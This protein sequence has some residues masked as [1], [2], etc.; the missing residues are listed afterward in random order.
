MMQRLTHSRRDLGSLFR[1]LSIAALAVFL[2]TLT[3][4]PDSANAVDKIA[5]RRKQIDQ[6]RARAMAQK[7]VSSAIDLQINQLEDNGLT[8]LPIYKEIRSM[9]GNIGEL[10]EA[11]M[12]D[13]VTMLLDAQQLD[14]AAERDSK[15]IS[16]RGTIRDIVIRLAVERHNLLRRLR[17]AEIAE[18]VKRLIRLEA[19][20]MTVTKGLPEVSQTRREQLAVR[21]IEDQ[22][23]I[24][25]LFLHLVETLAD[26][27]S[28]DGAIGQGATKG[29]G[30]LKKE[31]VG[32]HLDRAGTELAAAR[33]AASAIEQA[34]VVVGLK[35]LLDEVL[36]TQG[37][38]SSDSE[39]IFQRIEELAQK[40]S[41][42]RAKVQNADL[43]KPDNASDLTA[44]QEEFKAELEEL[45]EA[46]ADNPQAAEHVQEAIEAATQATEQIFSEQT[47]QA[48]SAQRLVEGHLAA[49]LDK[50]QQDIQEQLGDKTATELAATV[51]DLEATKAELEQV[52]AQQQTASVTAEQDPAKAAQ[53]EKAVAA[54]I[55]AIQA[56]VAKRDLP[57][58]LE[59]TIAAADEAV[60]NA[61]EAA[62]KAA[63]AKAP[64]DSEEQS[65][66]EEAFQNAAD[67]VE[68]ALAS[69]TESLAEAQRMEAAVKI[70]ELARA[71][72]AL[73]RAAAAERKI[74]ETANEIA[75]GEAVA[76]EAA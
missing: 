44:E 14:S 17:N 36:H 27:S 24:K 29:L 73:E 67:A 71:A 26:V 49:L 16:A 32:L 59:A 41:E 39:S 35:K 37:L 31:D 4:V 21:A 55:E 62:Q 38:I 50:L 53:Q 23:D 69:T 51:K 11:E 63:D 45:V 74:A 1:R 9:R 15:F 47:E 43:T 48:V 7:L 46:V 75:A 68:R 60:A 20:V 54:A 22:R 70:G 34:Q 19:A 8:D 42:I 25:G 58:Q 6:Q 12:A 64:T 3:G 5:L 10:V 33:F 76:P 66:S 28:W 18:Q 52:K 2:L 30:I 61:M 57:D 40:Q 65:N 56:A 13:V 72:E